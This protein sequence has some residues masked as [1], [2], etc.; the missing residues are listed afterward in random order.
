MEQEEDADALTW[1]GLGDTG[2]WQEMLD[3]DNEDTS[4]EIHKTEDI[5]NLNAN[6]KNLNNV[7]GSS[8]GTKCI[9]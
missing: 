7:N 6:H 1:G 9:D 3:D 2:K 5:A 4:D 8:Y